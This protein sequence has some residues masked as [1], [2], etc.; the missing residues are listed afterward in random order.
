MSSLDPVSSGNHCCLGG[1]ELDFLVT[2]TLASQCPPAVGRALGNTLNYSLAGTEGDRKFDKKVSENR[3]TGTHRVPIQLTNL[4]Q[5]LRSSQSIHYVSL[6]DGSTSNAHFL[7]A[8]NLARYAG[9]R[10]FKCPVVFGVSD[11]QVSI[12]LPNYGYLDAL[13]ESGGVRKFRADGNDLESVYKATKDAVDY[14]RRN[15][16]PSVVV[17]SGL[18]RRFGHA[19]T[20]RE[21]AYLTSGEIRSHRE[22][23]NLE[24]AVE[25][26]VGT[27][28]VGYEEVLGW[29]EEMEGGVRE[30]FDKA[31]GE[32]KVAERDEVMRQAMRPEVPTPRVLPFPQSPSSPTVGTAPGRRDVMRKSMNKAIAE[33]LDERPNL[34]Y[35]GEDVQH[36]GYYLVT[37]GLHRKYPK[38]VCD[39]PPDETTL[40]GAG[41]GYS[42][43]GLLPVVEI[44]YAKYLDCGYDMFEEAG[45]MNWLSG[46]RGKGMGMV[47][48]LQG[49]DRGTFGGNFHTH[50]QLHMPPGITTVCYSNGEDY[51]RGYRNAIRQAEGGR[52]TMLVDCTALLNLRHLT[53][54]DR[55][56]ERAFPEKDEVLSFHDV[57]RY[58][59][60]KGRGEVAIVTYGNGVVTGL[61]AREEFSDPSKIDVIDCMLLS[62]CPDG[63]VEELA[64]YDKIV[65]AGICKEG[66]NPLSGMLG[67]L[68]EG[69][70]NGGAGLGGKKW[71]FRA[72]QR[73]Y[74]PLGTTLTFL[75]VKDVLG[76]IEEVM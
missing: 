7:A 66:Q 58:G 76:G 37:D 31:S 28:E 5:S 62:E 11:N 27:G 10:S 54:K 24:R 72:A 61:Q 6:G 29:V 18:R 38:R 70:E 26:G 41:M 20:D 43:A 63:L 3:A 2:S 36:G 49:F 42:Q 1:G 56:W 21:N 17:Y 65:F 45:V 67:R 8:L 13:L 50:N 34:V 35:I 23:D 71:C 60:E 15:Q 40:V 14:S 55:G 19:A 53:G 47:I 12:S 39:F 52:I 25:W 44:P 68:N 51:A 64:C 16:K 33:S 46:G 57:R 4:S 69:V 22:A 75:N 59:D 30:A 9:H 32:P 74:N 48:R 73:T